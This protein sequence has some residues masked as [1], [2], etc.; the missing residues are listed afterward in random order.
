MAF[1]A[2]FLS[3]L[4]LIVGRTTFSRHIAFGAERIVYRIVP[5]KIIITIV[6]LL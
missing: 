6:S 1:I 4:H 3:L 5:L 2:K